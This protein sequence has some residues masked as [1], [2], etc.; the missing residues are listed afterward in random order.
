M[1]SAMHLH[2][3]QLAATSLRLPKGLGLISGA[4]F[5]ARGAGQ[6]PCYA[7]MHQ[8]RFPQV[9]HLCHAVTGKTPASDTVGRAFFPGVLSLLGNENSPEETEETRPR[10]RSPCT[11]L[12]FPPYTRLT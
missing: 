11:W 8:R 2:A 9:T 7:Y 10:L 3:V 5:L 1:I 4:P 6:P 12:P